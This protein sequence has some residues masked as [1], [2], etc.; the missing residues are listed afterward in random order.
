[1]QNYPIGDFLIRIKNASLANNK[2]V[3]MPSSK[4][5]KELAKALK[6]EK[7]LDSVE[8]SK[9]IIKVLLSFSHKKPVIMDVKLI[10]R[11]GLRVYKSADELK[12]VKRPTI[13]M[14]STPKGIMSAQKAIKQRVG[15]EVLAEI[16]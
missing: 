3:Q 5:V 6:E 8:D 2:E 7:L 1:M 13:F 9:G 12:K 14:V 4:F 11:P 10:S 15:G 16:L